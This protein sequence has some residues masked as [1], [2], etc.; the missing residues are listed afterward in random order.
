MKKAPS[1][2]VKGLFK[3]KATL[4]INIYLIKTSFL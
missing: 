4:F 2:E 1:H 3:T